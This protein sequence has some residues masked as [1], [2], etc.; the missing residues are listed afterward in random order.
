MCCCAHAAAITTNDKAHELFARESQT[1]MHAN[2]GVLPTG[3]SPPGAS[4]LL[5]AYA[6]GPGGMSG[7]QVRVQRAAGHP[8][9]A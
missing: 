8:Q 2:S 7:S 5:A 9:P 6:N 3:T 4:V 1:L